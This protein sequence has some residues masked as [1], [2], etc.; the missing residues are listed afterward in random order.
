MRGFLLSF[1]LP[2]ECA[3][4]LQLLL[5][6]DYACMRSEF[7][8]MLQD[9]RRHYDYDAGTIELLALCCSL[10]MNLYVRRR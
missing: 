8:Y 4:E 10:K 1:E 5:T 6:P 9:K 3:R 7:P 2:R